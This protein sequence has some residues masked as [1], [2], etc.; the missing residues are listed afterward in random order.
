MTGALSD[1]RIQK[2]SVPLQARGKTGTRIGAREV[3]MRP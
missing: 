3:M 1:R 2:V